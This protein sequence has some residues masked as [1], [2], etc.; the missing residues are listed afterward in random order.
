MD[1][2]NHLIKIFSDFPGIG[3]RQAKR[4][5]F[6]LL[7]RNGNYIENLASHLLELKK[8]IAVCEECFRFFEQGKTV[9]AFCDIC[10]SPNRD[11]KQLMIVSRD[12]D[13][14]TIEKSHSFNGHYFILG[15]SLPVL[16]PKPESKIRLK[17]L[18]V[19]VNRL[20]ENG[21]KEIILGLNANAEGEYTGNFLINALAPTAQK[22]D[23]KISHL[24][25][26]LS[27]GTELEYSDSETIKNALENR[28]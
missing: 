10:R 23:L 24:G 9:R 5:V 4:F 27:T 17:E 12:V 7:S 18:L 14:E 25:R 1:S 16:E 2:I 6:Y 13:L 22:F 28:K 26:G 3:P 19:G 11:N 8:E 15:G 20:A 21:L